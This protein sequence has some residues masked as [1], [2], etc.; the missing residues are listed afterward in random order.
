MSQRDEEII[1]IILD[2][3]QRLAEDK[4]YQLVAD[5]M[6]R[7]FYDEVA[8]L[9]SLEEAEGNEK[10]AQ[11]IYA[12]NRVRRLLDL[13]TE[14]IIRN[15]AQKEEKKSAD[16]KRKSKNDQSRRIR[17]KLSCVGAVLLT[18]FLAWFYQV[19]L[20][21]IDLIILIILII[22]LCLGVVR[23]IEKKSYINI[24]C[25][26]IIPFYGYFYSSISRKH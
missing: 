22:G 1:Q 2:L 17:T 7:G 10:Q 4:A 26:L 13:R 3:D 5:E 25:S 21:F 8:Q 19:D 18:F 24:I 12:R 11:A 9:R 15:A 14:S 16:E 20:K 23:G 6:K